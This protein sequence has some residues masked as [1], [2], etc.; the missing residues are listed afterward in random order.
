VK[1]LIDLYVKVIDGVVDWYVVNMLFYL[2]GVFDLELDIFDLVLVILKLVVVDLFFNWEDDEIVC[3]CVLW[4]EIVIYE[5]YVKG[6]MKFCSGV[7][8]DLCGIYGGFVSEDAIEYLIGLG[9][10]VVELLLVYY[11]IDEGFFVDCGLMNYWG[12]L[13]IGYFVSY[14]F[15]FVIGD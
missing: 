7:C 3:L 14:S 13:S 6:F 4:N 10:N 2:F 11:I 8:D 9:V 1:F 15:Y 5:V 12:Y